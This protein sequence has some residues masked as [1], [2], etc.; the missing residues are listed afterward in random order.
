M[1]EP[2]PVSASV[3]E[4]APASR[5]LLAAAL[6]VSCVIHLVLGWAVL[7]LFKP[8]SLD[9]EFEVPIDVELGL[10]EEVKAFEPPPAPPPPAPPVV[11]KAPGENAKDAEKDKDK[12]KT[13]E[14]AG[15]EAADAGVPEVA[16]AGPAEHDAGPPLLADPSAKPGERLPPGAQIAVRVDMARIRES[17]IAEDVRALLAAVPDWKALLEGSGIDPVD[18]L[19][20]LLIATPNLQRDKIVVAGRFVG[21]P[22]IVEEAVQRLAQAQ[23][24]EAHWRV[25]SG[26]RVAPWANK[27]ET[28]RVIA[29]VGPAHF[30]IARSEDLPRVL[31]IAAARAD[32]PKGPKERKDKSIKVHP[33]DALLS[34]EAGEGLSLEVDGVE[35]F[36]RKAKRGVPLKLRLSAVQVPGP[37]LELRGRMAFENAEKAADALRFWQAVRDTYARNALVMLLGLS[38]PLREGKLEQADNELHLTLQLTVEQT[39]LIVGYVRELIT[40]PATVAPSPAPAPAAPAPAAPTR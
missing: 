11:E 6:V 33:A 30:T 22:R 7:V 27:D 38:D 13:H 23:N 28:P 12:A 8:P 4:R 19:D 21:E 3:P 37:K 40:P 20:R 24:V 31:A 1:L 39:R 16:D 36:V 10:S 25:E 9:I 34:M 29:I 5:W 2:V 15:V 35:R 32:D 18:Q 17:P 14:D 26:V